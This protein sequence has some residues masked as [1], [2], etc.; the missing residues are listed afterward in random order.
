[1]DN[2][3][4]KRHLEA[5]THN[6]NRD[7]KKRKVNDD[8]DI[9][10]RRVFGNAEFRPRQRAII[11][12]VMEGSDV[13]VIMPTG[14]GKSLC[15]Q[16][17]AVLTCGVTI[18]ISPLISLIEDQVSALIQLPSGGVPAAYLT[19]SC[20]ETMLRSVFQDL[21]RAQQGLEPYLKLLYVT[22]ERIVNSLNTRDFLAQLYQNEMLARFVIDEAH[23]ISSWGHDFRK[24]Y[25]QLNL[26][27][28]EF[29][30]VPILALTATARKQVVEDICKVLRIPTAVRY[31]TG[32]DRSNLI[33]E[34]RDKPSSLAEA[35]KHVLNYINKRFRGASGI[36]YCMT[37]KDTEFLADFLRE[38]NVLVDYYHAG[39]TKG[40]RKAVQSAW[41]RGD[42]KVVCATIAYGMGIDKPDVRF[43]VHLSL[44]AGRAGRDGLMSECVL[45]YRHSDV[46]SLQRIMAKPPAYRIS[47]KDENRLEEMQKYCESR[48]DCRR[49][50]FSDI[51]GFNSN[52]TFRNCDTLCDNCLFRNGTPRRNAET[53][54]TPED[55]GTR[56]GSAAGTR[57]PSF[58]K[59][60][61]LRRS[62]L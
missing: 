7:D 33:F 41:L 29:P 51:F 3:L 5:E 36:V 15:Y 24:E 1:M 23:C 58:Q 4:K 50:I 56:G 16:L 2:F 54:K 49:K 20:T 57:G 62:N 14:G 26:L 10:N 52:I 42:V 18:V 35:F 13:F 22:P 12:S 43:V 27:K 31:S 9:A 48:K 45:F 11:E 60:S 38:N 47:K 21:G 61:E 6:D 8:L 44:E 25:G 53:E 34:V 55:S 40:E 37:K 19:S 46:T 39:Q 17:P 28:D 59:A 32:F 30:E